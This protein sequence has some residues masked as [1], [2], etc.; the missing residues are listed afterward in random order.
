MAEEVFDKIEDDQ[1]SDNI[2]NELNIDGNHILDDDQIKQLKELLTRHKD[3]FS[4]SDTDIGLCNKVKH[5]IELLG[6]ILFK[7]RHRRIPPNMLE[8]VRQHIEQLLAGGIIRPSKSPW[9]VYTA[10]SILQ[11]SI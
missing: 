11:L 8:K 10:Q 5:R 3:I 4:T 2:I 9:T 1:K 6:G 7:Q